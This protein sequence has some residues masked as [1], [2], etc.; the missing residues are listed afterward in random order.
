MRTITFVRVEGHAKGGSASV[1]MKY[2]LG[3]GGI[4]RRGSGSRHVAKKDEADGA[5]WGERL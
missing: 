3:S 5:L 2:S 1:P 4:R